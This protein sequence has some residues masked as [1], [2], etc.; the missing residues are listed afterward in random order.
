MQQ[1]LVVSDK[2]QRFG[3]A[4]FLRRLAEAVDAS[5]MNVRLEVIEMTL[6]HEHLAALEEIRVAE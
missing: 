6:R 4:D 1:T 5:G 2:M 3:A